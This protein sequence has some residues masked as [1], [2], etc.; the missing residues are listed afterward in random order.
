MEASKTTPTI[1]PLTST[2]APDLVIGNPDEAE[3]EIQKKKLTE[4]ELKRPEF[5]KFL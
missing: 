3:V 2:T 1:D 5:D 4:K